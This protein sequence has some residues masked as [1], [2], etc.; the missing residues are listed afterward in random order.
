MPFTF[1]NILN[2]GTENPIVARL[3]LQILQILNQCN[4]AKDKKDKISDIYLKTLS[5]NSRHSA[6]P[7]EYIVSLLYDFIARP[8]SRGFPGGNHQKNHS[9][10][11]RG[12]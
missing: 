10:R 8:T 12:F 3:S 6:V 4:I 11:G 2:H 5:A 9:G 1:S 7:F